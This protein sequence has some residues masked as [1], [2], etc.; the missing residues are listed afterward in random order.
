M[1]IDASAHMEQIVYRAKKQADQALEAFDSDAEK[2]QLSSGGTI[3]LFGGNAVDQVADI[4]AD[5]RR[6]CDRLYAT[7]QMLVKMVDEECKPLLN[8]Q[9]SMSAVKKVA[10]LI[11]WL[12]SE[13][14]LGTNFAASLN[15][16]NLGTMVSGKY[17]PTME[18]KMIQSYW[19]TKSSTWPDWYSPANAIPAKSG[20]KPQA[21]DKTATKSVAEF[22]KEFDMASG[23]KN[24]RLTEE[25]LAYKETVLRWYKETA[26]AEKK[27]EDEVTKRV[28]EAREKLNRQAKAQ[29]DKIVAEQTQII[30]QMQNKMD[31]AQAA[32]DGS[33]LFQI[34]L[35]KTEQ[36]NIDKAIQ[37]RTEAA[38]AIEKAK[39]SYDRTV[40]HS[41]KTAEQ[42]R[43]SIRK[44]VFTSYEKP[45]MP[46]PPES[47]RILQTSNLA[48]QKAIAASMEPGRQYS[49]VDIQQEIPFVMN[50]STQRIAAMVRQMVPEQLACIEKNG[51]SYF[52]V[53]P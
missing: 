6:V 23:R 37:C 17:I 24:F 8:R 31:A 35:R 10:D 53:I 21:G 9:P 46:Q 45:E 30:D 43:E 32:I 12:N 18:A 16:K 44:K 3:D 5:V 42:Q 2:V 50:L 4:A 26:E 48:I 51:K 47:I 39:R 49:T 28:A 38:A 20:S 11:K 40:A 1:S 14:E 36:A 13:S 52:C 25:E 29:Y 22:R 15:G 27:L 19:E 33:K 41:G 7:L 34:S